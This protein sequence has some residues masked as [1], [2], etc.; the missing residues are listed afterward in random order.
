MKGLSRFLVTVGIFA[1]PEIGHCQET[2]SSN[3]NW[4]LEVWVSFATGGESTNSL[5]TRNI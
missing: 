3:R 1:L 5:S 4:D 2:P